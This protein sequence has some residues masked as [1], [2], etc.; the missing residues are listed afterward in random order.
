V[1]RCGLSSLLDTRQPK[2]ER[3]D[4]CHLSYKNPHSHPT[5][6]LNDSREAQVSIANW[7][8]GASQ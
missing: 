1:S 7:G 4:L 3:Q 8:Q 6:A 5:V 2:A